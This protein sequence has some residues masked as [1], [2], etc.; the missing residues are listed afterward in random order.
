MSQLVRTRIE[1]SDLT[2]DPSTPLNFTSIATQTEGYSVT[3]LEDLVSRAI[4]QAVIRSTNPDDAVD[5]GV[6]MFPFVFDLI[7]GSQLVAC[8]DD[9]NAGRLRHC[10]SR[11]HTSVSERCQTAKVR[12]SMG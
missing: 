8:T 7:G 9:N 11:L 4:H 1:S 6:S 12:G 10:P 5:V 3:D 2:M